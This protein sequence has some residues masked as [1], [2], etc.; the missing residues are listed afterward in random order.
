M[1]TFI[2]TMVSDAMGRTSRLEQ[3]TLISTRETGKT[4][5]IIRF[6]EVRRMDQ[7]EGISEVRD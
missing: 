6:E 5:G 2:L 7:R 1:A 3:G 4:K